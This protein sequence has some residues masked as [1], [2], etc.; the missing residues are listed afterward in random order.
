MMYNTSLPG[1][2]AI[3]IRLRNLTTGA[4]HLHSLQSRR[5]GTLPASRV[6]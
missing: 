6:S 5:R 2:H 3:T 4:D 1:D